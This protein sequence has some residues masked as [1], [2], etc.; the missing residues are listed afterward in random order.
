VSRQVIKCPDGSYAV[1]SSYTDTWVACC[2][3][4]HEDVVAEFEQYHRESWPPGREVPEFR[5]DDVLWRLRMLDSGTKRV[6]GSFTL[7]F[8]QANAQS[9][10]HG[11]EDYRESH[12]REDWQGPHEDAGRA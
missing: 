10:E 7:T 9:V 1:F 2:G 6:Y 12:G 3:F 8:D 4:T 11:G 5:A